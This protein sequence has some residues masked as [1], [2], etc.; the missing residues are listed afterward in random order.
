M[1][2][3]ELTSSFITRGDSP[4]F[5]LVKVPILSFPQRCTAYVPIQ[6]YL[7][8]SM[9]RAGALFDKIKN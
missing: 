7:K 4:A 3:F 9:I 6:A 2:K 8:L 5:P 1:H